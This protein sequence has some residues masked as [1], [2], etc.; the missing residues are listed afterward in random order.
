MVSRI[1]G[2]LSIPLLASYPLIATLSGLT[3]ALG[4]NCASVI[5]NLLSVSIITGMFLL[6]NRAVD[7]NGI[8]MTLMSLFK[9]AGPAGGGA[10]FS[11]AQKRQ[12]AAFLPG[13]NM[14]FFVSNVIE[15]FGV[16]MTF[17]PFLIER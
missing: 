10:I 15:A 9:A 2:V 5:K 14:V 6:Q 7:P 16:L 11:W 1:S 12:D 13:D 17:K 8:A 3:L 4:L